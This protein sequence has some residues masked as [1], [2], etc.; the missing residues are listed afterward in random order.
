MVVATLSDSEIYGLRPFLVT[1]TIDCCRW[2]L[3][4]L[5]TSAHR[6]DSDVVPEMLAVF[7]VTRE[8]WEVRVFW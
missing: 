8:E 7:V 5:H 1:N 3:A 4:S 2:F 6:F